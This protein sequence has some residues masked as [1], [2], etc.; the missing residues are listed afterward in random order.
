MIVDGVHCLTDSNMDFRRLTAQVRDRNS[1]IRK[2]VLT[3]AY[4]KLYRLTAVTNPDPATQALRNELHASRLPF[5]TRQWRPLTPD[6]VPEPTLVRC[7]PVFNRPTTAHGVRSNLTSCTGPQRPQSTPAHGLRSPHSSLHVVG[8]SPRP[9]PTPRL[10]TPRVDPGRFDTLSPRVLSQ[11]LDDVQ[12]RPFSASYGDRILTRPE[13]RPQRK[14][15]G[16]G[17]SKVNLNDDVSTTSGIESDGGEDDDVSEDDGE[18]DDSSDSENGG[19]EPSLDD[20]R[21]QMPHPQSVFRLRPEKL[22]AIYVPDDKRDMRR[23]DFDAEKVELPP[24]EFKCPLPD[25][26][27]KVNLRLCAR[28]GTDWQDYLHTVP[29]E[30]PAL[31]GLMDRLVE[32]ENYQIITEDWEAKK[33]RGQIRRQEK[34]ALNGGS[35]VASARIRDKRCCGLCLQAACVGDCPE[36]RQIPGRCEKCHQP[37]CTGACQDSHYEQRMRQARSSDSLI[38][39]EPP[40]PPLPRSPSRGCYSCLRRHNAKLINANNLMMGRP[41]SSNATYSRGQSSCRPRDLRPTSAASLHSTL[42]KDFE[43]LGI[44]PRQP[45]PPSRPSTARPRSRNG[46]LPGKSARSNRKNSISDCGNKRKK[47]KQGRGAKGRQNNS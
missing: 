20:L 13:R 15:E 38:L 36:K 19:F 5:Q 21:R 28:E 31:R 46:L 40:P 26:L 41:K 16:D 18:D 27:H 2:Q 42:L 1:V 23:F 11:L 17:E 12:P 39:D 37:L 29:P 10:D 6:E 32:L 8:Y 34:L 30:A 9:P 44:E 14:K 4:Q 47:K 45:T 22:D 33:L 3:P 43:R 24:Y 7:R 35:R 25:T